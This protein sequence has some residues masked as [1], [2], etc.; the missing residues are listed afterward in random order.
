MKL[1]IIG[2]SVCGFSAHGEHDSTDRPLK[3]CPFCG[4]SDIT[5]TNTHSPHYNARCE[6]CSAEGPDGWD[7][8]PEEFQVL[9]PKMPKK[10][11]SKART[12]E[13]HEAAFQAAIDAWN[14]R[15]CDGSG[16]RDRPMPE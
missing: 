6:D 16:P 13:I 12:I 1:K 15:Y 5:L 10:R 7:Y 3:P 11:M 8:I 14:N 4:G 2:G 9:I